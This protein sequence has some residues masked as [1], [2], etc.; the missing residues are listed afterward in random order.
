MA[1]LTPTPVEP[2]GP[3]P[4]RTPRPGGGDVP[5]CLVQAA[6]ISKAFYGLQA[7]DAVD[8]DLRA[9]EVHALLG[10]NGAGKS[11]LCSILAGAYRPDDGTLTVGGVPRR[12][13]APNDAL[14]AGIGMVYQHYRLVDRFTVAENLFLAHPD[15][16]HRVA[17]RRLEARAREAMEAFGLHLDPHR[18][19]GDLTVGEQQRVEIL[20]LLVR[21]VRVLILDEPTA[22]LT[23]QES[24][25]LFAVMRRLAAEG[26]GIVF[27]S[28][29]LAEVL[30]VSDRVTVLR[31]GRRIA[32][33]AAAE[34]DARSVAR[35][36]VDRGEAMAGATMRAPRPAAA[37]A[38]SPGRTVLRVRGLRAR[39]GRRHETVCGLDLDVRGGEVVGVAGVSGNGQREL[40][41]AIAG[42]VRASAGSIVLDDRDVTTAPARE[43]AARGLAYVPEDRLAMGVASG[44]SLE[45]NLVLRSYRER[46][47]GRGPFLSRRRCARVAAG[48]IERFD[49][50]GARPG[51]PVRALSGGNVQR[52]ILARELSGSPTLVLAA[53]PTRG[54]DVGATRAV[55][56]LLRAQRERGA[57]VLLISE[58]LEEVLDVSDRIVV[59]YA[60]RV[61]GELPVA[62]AEPERLGLLMAGGAPARADGAREA[63]EDRA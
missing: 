43:R 47:L 2:V 29:K 58:D 53:A 52:A 3:P 18:R 27:V 10:E 46:A 50:R 12:F 39:D 57:G 11:T 5:A 49:I 24:E 17:P 62:E 59:L 56:D 20:A 9:G 63:Q 30:A 7:N 14:A 55:R 60:G 44:L 6:G 34:T 45:E 23:P 54:L 35:M 19:V 1:D 36:M 37:S 41:D 21:G 8:F 4:G 32:T 28:H 33:L 31:D 26:R 22:V 15:L 40:A 25:R 38:A 48:L 61:A 51:L 13:R 42:V 16:A